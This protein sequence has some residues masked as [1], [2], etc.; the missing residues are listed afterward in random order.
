MIVNNNGRVI[1]VACNQG[2]QLVLR[3]VSVFSEAVAL[4]GLLAW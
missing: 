3:T 4:L 2:L 1:L